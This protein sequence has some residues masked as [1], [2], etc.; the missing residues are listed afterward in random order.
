MPN[1]PKCAKQAKIL[2]NEIWQLIG[3]LGIFTNDFPDGG[4][5]FR[6]HWAN[7]DYAISVSI[8][9]DINPNPNPDHWV[10]ETALWSVKDNRISFSGNFD[11][12]QD[13]IRFETPKEVIAEILR[14]AK[15]TWKPR[16]V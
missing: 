4:F 14:V 11:Y 10:Y 7:P 2:F 5:S 16:R 8:P 13:V 12:I 6:V 15:L 3:F 1:A 9:P